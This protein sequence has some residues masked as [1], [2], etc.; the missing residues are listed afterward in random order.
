[1]PRQSPRKCRPRT[2]AGLLARKKNENNRTQLPQTLARD[3]SP[4]RPPALV[5][6][7]IAHKQIPFPRGISPLR[8]DCRPHSGRNDI[9]KQADKK[10][11]PLGARRGGMKHRKNSPQVTVF[12]QSGP[13]MLRA[14]QA[15]ATRQSPGREM[16]ETNTR[17]PARPRWLTAERSEPSGE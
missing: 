5:T 17:Q 13:A 3:G 10:P 14:G 11:P 16:S 6:K 15:S 9:I 1:M 7:I 2:R 8:S 4:P 12:S